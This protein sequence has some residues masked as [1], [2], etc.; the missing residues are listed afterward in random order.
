VLI[1]HLG[2]GVDNIDRL[3]TEARADY[4]PDH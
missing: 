1:A 2:V 3:V 4:D